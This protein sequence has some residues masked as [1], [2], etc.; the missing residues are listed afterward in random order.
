MRTTRLSVLKLFF[1]LTFVLQPL[2]AAQPAQAQIAT[3]SD[4]A[5]DK[6]HH[7]EVMLTADLPARADQPINIT[8]TATPQLAAPD[9]PIVW[10][11]PAGGEL[12]GGAISESAG[13]VA[14]HQ[15]VHQTR[16]LRLTG[17]GVH[18]LTVRASYR[19]DEALQFGATGVLFFTVNADGTITASA[20]DP[21][22]HSPMHSKMPMQVTQDVNA[23]AT[24]SPTD[25][26][27]FDVS[28]IITRIEKV[29]T[30]SGLATATTVPV[31]NVRVEMRE[32]DTLFDDSYGKVV[33]DNNGAYHFNFCDDDGVFD[34]ELELYVRVRTE[35]FK[36]GHSVVEVEDSSWIDEVY[37]YDSN[38]I[39][40]E[41][42]TYTINFNLNDE[43]SGILNIADAVLDAWTTWNN[44]GGAKGNDAI[45][46]GEAEVHWEAGYG[47]TGSYYNG[48]VWNEMTIAD[49]P[50]DPDQWDDSVIM[51]EWGHMADDY[52][53]CD[54]NGGGPHN[55]DTL[56]NDLELSWGEGYPDFWQSVVRDKTGHQDSSWYL[57]FDIN[58]NVNIG[59]NLE[60]YDST[61]MA[62]LL[63]DQ[64]E[65]AI[66]AMLWDLYDTANDGRTSAGVT[67]GPWDRVSPGQPIIQEVYTDP[68]FESNGDVFDDTCTASVYLEA[69]KKLNKP[70]DAGTAEAV[71]KNLGKS[72]P[73]GTS[74]V[75]ASQVQAAGASTT[76]ATTNQPDYRWWKQL[77][78]VVDNSASMAQSGKL[79]AVKVV[80]NE[81]VN[82]IVAPDPKGI[83]VQINTFNNTSLAIQN[84]TFGQFFPEGITP[85][86]NQLTTIGAADPNCQVNALNALSQAIQN[87]RGG[88]AWVY[89]DGD[90]TQSPSL[91]L[92]K[93]QLNEHQVRGSIALLGGCNSPARPNSS[94]VS[95]DEESYLD[96]AA[97]GS[98]SSGIVPYLLTAL[99]SG[100]QFLFVNK[101]QLPDAADILRAQLGN[102][103]GAGKWSDYVSDSFTYR[104]DKLT[105]RE[106]Q[107]FPA[108][109]LGQDQGQVDPSGLKELTLPAP[110]P[111]YGST[112]TR[113]GVSQDGFIKFDPCTPGGGVLCPIFSSEY[114]NNLNTDLVWSS[115]YPPKVAAD[116]N[117]ATSATIDQVNAGQTCFQQLSDPF[118]YGPHVCVYTANLGFEWHI[119][120][121]QGLDQDNV[122]RAY[123]VWLNTKTGEIR[124]QY[125]HVRNE[126]NTA[127]IGL[128]RF[129]S[130]PLG[131]SDKLI[132]S[133]KDVAGATNGMG[134][135]FTPA[136]PQPTKTYTVNV[137]SL[138]QSVGFLQTGYSGNFAPMTVTDPD[139]NAVN[140]GDT[141]NVLCLTVD[142]NAG[143]KLVQY[144]Q[145]NVNG[146][147]GKWHATVD[148][149]AGG[150]GTFSFSALAASDL[151]ADSPTRRLL[152]SAG[153]SAIQVKFGRALDG[154]TLTGWLQKPNGQR[155]G[156]EF[157][158]FDDGAHGDE[159]AGDGVFGWPD[160]TPPSR[161]V[162][163]LWTKGAVGGVEFERSDPAP[164]N[165]QPFRVTALDK[166]VVNNNEPTDIRFQLDN[167]DSRDDCF[168]ADIDLPAGWS[169]K[170]DFDQIGCLNIPAGQSVT[171]VLTVYP[172]WPN[173]LSGEQAQITVSFAETEEGSISD[174]DNATLTRRRPPASIEFDTR[175]ADVYLRPNSSDV[176]S[177]T[178]I[179]LDNQG[180]IV[181]DG[182]PV[183]VSTSLGNVAPVAV[184]AAA[185]NS[186]NVVVSTVDG[187]SVV[188]FTPG[189][190]E[191]DATITANIGALSATTT[192][193]IRNPIANQI[194]LAA[195][196]T[197]LSGAANSAVLM[198]TVLDRWGNPVAN[199]T[200]RI[201]TEGDG[202]Q[203]L[204]NGSEVMTATT[205]AQGQ[206]LTN[207]T[208]A[209][210][211]A[212]DVGVR[213]ELLATVDGEL[214]IVHED[215]AV[216]QLSVVTP[217]SQKIYL[218]L[219]V[220]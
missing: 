156:E 40:S 189:T 184:S 137:D 139:G 111:F 96:L 109:S 37:E 35:L 2:L 215:R 64:N 85:R 27:C 181:A 138:I 68:A 89:T 171:Q 25:D 142:H 173:A 130:F 112:H 24:R 7:I 101:D 193:H 39:E 194:H 82:D 212:G 28:G 50:S 136:P 146:H 126:A 128:S 21:N 124:Y 119:V 115:Y 78:F 160:F 107:W 49:D 209:T 51:H 145:V 172:D 218:P 132:V 150:Q 19:P 60:T 75:A 210:A 144:I 195:T 120:S 4:R 169:Y 41:G 20:K 202:Q 62:S 182:T 188:R 176:I 164:F 175:Y 129:F 54:D 208:K 6:Q 158:M 114:L 163:Y 43:Q 220:R 211:A 66:A 159:R 98:Q 13:A 162:G 187:R 166:H 170:W 61:R 148:A 91:P 34:D 108:E 74:L 18:R 106:Y 56:V 8:L 147:T 46:D 15:A 70:T 14:A 167:L 207:F 79:D 17:V 134:Y 33:T 155:F 42:G 63:S 57:D 77:N 52:Y 69:W 179:V 143:D 59:V 95:G 110:F 141:I 38:I 80:M 197:D 97:D 217:P 205:N 9:L 72:D 88:Q 105:S 154:N 87:Q 177:L 83:E 125:E 65:L 127:E 5:E 117:N 47:D 204:V 174:S 58:G 100:G 44:N 123:Q 3:V 190:T 118:M 216:L 76:Y 86:I 12:L 178:A 161:G 219:V 185:A 73:F 31:R 90:T 133:N 131:H 48:D 93:R 99:G 102:S 186:T 198:A 55:V 71:T 157:T 30:K 16:Q 153:K 11:V 213:A 199:Q 45:F 53:G 203:G 180:G 32:Q 113:I 183:N 116:A 36:D 26:P 84:S 22:A 94:A 165:F 191:G 149:G 214:K 140:C 168:D 200:V 206:V 103:A 10:T 1:C 29:P 196:P 135:K 122:Y 67:V 104:W 92:I 152:P 201:G 121:T 81:T 192:I 151:N 23:A